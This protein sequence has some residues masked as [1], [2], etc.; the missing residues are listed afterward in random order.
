M[1]AARE[2]LQGYRASL[3]DDRRNVVDRFELVDIAHK[4]V[5]V[6]SVGTRCWIALLVG[7]DESDPLVLQ[8]KEAGPSVLEPYLGASSY[9]NHG[10]RVVEGQRFMQATSDIF[11]GWVRNP[12]AVD[13]GSR[14][15]YVRQLWD[16]K[17]S[18]DLETIPPEALAIYAQVCGWTVA[19]AHARSG[20][21]I[22]IAAYLGK[23][24][25]FDKAIANYAVAYADVAEQDYR[26]L[27]A[28][29]S[30]GRIAVH[31]G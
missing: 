12:Q 22:A 24:D 9:A 26:A 11:L 27:Q 3:S 14:D 29:A 5:G 25:V 30:A 10:Q 13:G 21:R 31:E 4:T 28:A 7:R 19:R 8:V 16:W 6:G 18:V 15:F 1:D 17:T 20:D 2:V 23:S